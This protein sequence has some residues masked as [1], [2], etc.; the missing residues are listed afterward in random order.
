MGN[1]YQKQASSLITT[2][3]S[4]TTQPIDSPALHLKTCVVLI[5][6][7]CCTCTTMAYLPCVVMTF[8]VLYQIKSSFIVT[9]A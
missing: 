4:I 7:A 8:I 5:T 2:M 6:F 3:E 1:L 9:Y